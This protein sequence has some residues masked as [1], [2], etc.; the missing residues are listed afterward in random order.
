MFGRRRSPGGG[1]VGRNTRPSL[2]VPATTL[3]RLHDTVL[4]TTVAEQRRND[5]VLRQ[6]AQTVSKPPVVSHFRHHGY[7][8]GFSI[9]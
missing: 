9:V 4:A 5:P 1:D 6:R 2:V 7:E 3:R 8:K